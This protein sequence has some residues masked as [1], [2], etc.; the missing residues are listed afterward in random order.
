MPA[1]ESNWYDVTNKKKLFWILQLCGWSGLVLLAVNVLHG[2]A[3]AVLPV[4][5]C[6]GL[7]GLIVTSF[8]VRPLA[9]W[10]RGRSTAEIKWWLPVMFCLVVV[11]S[12]ADSML[13][14][15][16]ATFASG[17][18]EIHGAALYFLNSSGPIRF[19][20]YGSWLVFYFVINNLIESNS[21]RLRLERLK[22]G[23]IES[24]LRLLRAQVNPHFLFNA[25]NSIIAE[26]GRPERVTRITQ[27]LADYLRFS[28]SQNIELQPLGE[29]LVALEGYLQV[30]KIRFEERLEYSLVA[31]EEVRRLRVPGALVQPLLENA[32]K[33]GQHTSP[34]PLR[35]SIHAEVR[36]EG[37]RIEVMNTGKWVPEGGRTSTGIGLVNLRRRLLLICGDRAHVAHEVLEDRVI[38]RVLIPPASSSSPQHPSF[39]VPA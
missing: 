33:F 30:E 36:P 1:F 23:T 15:W 9:R 16:L 25:L 10:V 13:I 26:A 32:I 18:G 21:A 4:L 8:V 39:P 7:F 31:D 20:A 11:L 35:I 12:L 14:R 38:F 27:G 17:F 22:A 19:I 6:R 28:L 37:L 3:R 29:E 2:D 24:E 34:R 5:V